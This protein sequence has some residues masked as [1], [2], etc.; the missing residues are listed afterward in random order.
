[1]RVTGDCFLLNRLPASPRAYIDVE[2]DQSLF[3]C[4]RSAVS[5]D[6]TSDQRD[7]EQ[8]G[9]EI[10]YPCIRNGKFHHN[11]GHYP[12]SHS[13]E[14]TFTVETPP[15]P[16]QYVGCDVSSEQCTYNPLED[17]IDIFQEESD[18]G[19][20][21]HYCNGNDIAAA[22]LCFHTCFRVNVFQ[23]NIIYDICRGCIDGR[24]KGRHESCQ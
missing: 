24:S 16:F 13:P 22:Y 8:Y 2:V 15:M 20:H 1:M 4:S 14:V 5:P 7:A 17:F 23:I 21:H 19:A 6:D 10:K 12:G 18:D 9:E 11:S 3:I